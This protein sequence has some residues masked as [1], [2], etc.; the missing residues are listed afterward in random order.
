MTLPKLYVIIPEDECDF[1]IVLISSDNEEDL[2]GS[3][4]PQYDTLLMN[5]TGS[6]ISATLGALQ[7]LISRQPMFNK[8]IGVS[9]GAVLSYLLILKYTPSSIFRFLQ[10]ITTQ[11]AFGYP[12]MFSFINGDGA[13]DYDIIDE[14]LE[15]LTMDVLGKIP[16]MNELYE[17]TGRELHIYTYNDTYKMPEYINFRTFPN[18]SVL[19]AL[20][21][22]CN[23]PFVFG[24]YKY[25]DCYYTDGAIFN[26]F[27]ITQLNRDDK[28]LGL[29]TII[30]RPS[31]FR[32]DDEIQGPKNIIETVKTVH[33]T[34]FSLS[35]MIEMMF[36]TNNLVED[37][38]ENIP[39]TIVHIE[40]EEEEGEEE[41]FQRGI[42]TMIDFFN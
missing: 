11:E 29:S 13:Y 35:R 36:N 6:Y 25:N 8:Y 28:T 5:G 32:S 4:I 41:K 42:H 10:T 27:P 33:M 20:R 23:I 21:M 39:L 18:M 24:R 22:A 9:S 12:N 16:T 2:V 19:V 34:F 31:I 1:M 17:L 37:V 40:C 3:I 30:P 15:Y 38:D 26:N 14:V 7:Y